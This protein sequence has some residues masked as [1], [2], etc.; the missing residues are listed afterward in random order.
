MADNGNSYTP[1]QIDRLLALL[2]DGQSLRSVC[3]KPDMPNKETVFRWLRTDEEFEARYRVAKQ[4]SADSLV[5]EMR[6]IVDDA[7][8]DPNDKRVR[9][10]ARKWIASKMK[11]KVYGDKVQ[12]SGDD[13][14][15]PL[16]IS[17]ATGDAGNA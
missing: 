16:V 17:W 2:A 10:D 8:L 6:D 4:E 12:L 7:G 5:D 15:A 1:E 11:P 13:D 14:G 3:S 9:I